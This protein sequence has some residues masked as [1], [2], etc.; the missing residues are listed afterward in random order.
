MP[1]NDSPRTS[2]E[3]IDAVSTIVEHWGKV[4]PELDVSP[5]E[6][7]G[8]LHRSFLLYRAAINAQFE[9]VG[10]T[11]PGFDVLAALRRAEPTFT[12][13]A[14]ELAQQTLITTGGLS[15]R[16]NRLEKEGLV[17]RH[18]D[19]HDQRIVHVQL[20]ASGLRTIERAAVAHYDNLARLLSGMTDE[21][22]SQL[23]GLLAVLFDSICAAEPGLYPREA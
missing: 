1:A 16:V 9:K 6:I 3:P 22:V 11:E 4:W 14:G 23:A 8:R 19:E 12:L 5:L 17:V 7:F 13:T 18:R 15:L 2:S 20:T 21:Q 10:T